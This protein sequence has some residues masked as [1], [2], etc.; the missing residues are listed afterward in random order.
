MVDGIVEMRLNEELIENAL[1]KQLRVRKMSGVL[2]YSE[3]DV[4]EY[5]AGEG[6]VTF[7]PVAQ[8]EAAGGTDGEGSP[9]EQQTLDDGDGTDQ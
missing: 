4:Y 6:I 3:W 2:T 1:I 5:T 8:M 9:G 7:D